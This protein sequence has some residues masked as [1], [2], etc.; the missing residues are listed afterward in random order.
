MLGKRTRARHHPAMTWTG[1]TLIMLSVMM[2]VPAG[3]TDLSKAVVLDMPPDMIFEK[4]GAIP[5]TA[6]TPEE[7]AAMA[8]YRFGGDT[9]KV[10]AI[11]LEWSDRPGQYPAAHFDSLLFS[12][13]AYP[14]GSVADYYHEVSFGQLTVTGQV[15]DWHNAG[16]Y[17]PYFGSYDF[18]AI[19]YGLDPIIDYSQFDGDQNGDVD[20]VVFIRSGNGE[21]DSQDP[22]DI[23]S[24]AIVYSPGYGPGP[25]DGLHVPRWNTSPETV[26]LRD[27]DNPTQFSGETGPSRIRVFAHEMAH[28]IGI[29]DLYDYDAKLTVPT[30]Y[31][32]S[33]SNDHPVYD[34]CV[35]GYGGYGILSIGSETPSHL[36]G[37]SKRQAGWIEPITL[38]SGIHDDLVI[39]D[40]ETHQDSS[41]YLVPIDMAEGEYFLL[42]FRNPRSTG[43][44]DKRDSD[45]SCYFFPDLTFGCDTL[46]RGLLITHV[47][48]SLG[49]YFWRINYGL[50]RYPHYTVAVE[51][52]GYN[53]A[54]DVYSNPGG[55]PSDSAQW[56]YPYESRKGAAF[57]DDVPGQQVFDGNSAPNSNGYSFPTG[58]AI[59]VDS[60]VDDK[61]YASVT[62]ITDRDG[63]GVADD[64]DNCPDISNPDQADG[65]GDGFG[66][67]CEPE[68]CDTI[69]TS[70]L[71]LAVGS[72][73]NCGHQAAA[74]YT[75]DYF[76]QGDC[77]SVYLYDGSPIIIWRING[78]EAYDVGYSIY[79]KD[80]FTIL[81]GHPAIPTADS[82]A[83]QIYQ[84][85]TFLAAAG[86]V[87]VEKIWYAPRQPDSCNFVI[88]CLRLFSQST[89]ATTDLAIGELLDW[90]IPGENG[91][92][93]LTGHNEDA[94]LV[95]LQGTGT[96]CIDNDRRF[97]GQAFLGVRYNNGNLDTSAVPYGALAEANASYTYGGINAAEFYGL[98]Q[99]PGFTSFPGG[100]QDMFSLMTYFNSATINPTDT[101][102]IF[103]VLTTVRDGIA[104]NL[105]INVIKARRW[106]MAHLAGAFNYVAGDA[107][108]DEAVNLADAVYIINYVFKGGPAPVPMEAGDAN[109]D[110]TT[111]LADAVYL[112][113]YI[114][115][116]GPEP[117]CP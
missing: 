42:E 82:A 91:S 66:D 90:D 68:T 70:C 100:A 112:V 55:G 31:T 72:R 12:R 28:N 59:R 47:H 11:L 29:P 96:G 109:C 40:I 115:K 108:G 17:T 106:L 43:K 113:N 56:W 114:F 88:Q 9:L 73:G 103:T 18:E 89:Q 24:Y 76:A 45:F 19:L 4:L 3:T 20:A 107:N 30:F 67:L 117:G 44:F 92:F 48:D 38:T 62:N 69:T 95:Y 53:P 79:G 41:L 37:W 105:I 64:V 7:D 97:G 98:M 80:L 36:C 94:K 60:I 81:P 99:T 34:W 26:P 54:H 22:N 50:P 93:D 86:R 71:G 16:Y 27:P 10:L 33:D 14:G 85:E 1:L 104:A 52:A 102:E 57:S 65:D 2:A 110:G 83:Y 116:G 21:E 46:D 84:T 8:A 6:L 111:N 61:L 77:E 13:D 63:D 75:M 74:G 39:Y 58:I 51:D 35:M 5:G 49:A 23:W 78:G 101:V 25:L 87:G 15:I 32:P